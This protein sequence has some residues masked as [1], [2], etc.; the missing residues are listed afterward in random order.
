MD[1]ACKNLVRAS[2]AVAA[3][4]GIS[5]LAASAAAGGGSDAAKPPVPLPPTA[6][7]IEYDSAGGKL[8]F[9]STAS[10]KELAVFYRAA[11]GAEGWVNHPTPINKDTIA[12][13]EFVRGKSG[14]DLTF[15]RIGDHT[16]VS[17]HGDALRDGATEAAA[18]GAPDTDLTAEDK[19]GLPVP[20]PHTLAGSERTPFRTSVNAETPAD[21]AAVVAFYRSEL[22]KRGWAEQV[23][24][25]SVRDDRAELIFDS[26]TGPATLMLTRDGANTTA[27]LTVRDKAAAMKSTLWPKPGQVKVAFGNMTDKAVE[28]SVAGKR[29]KIAAG[30]GRGAPN[31]PTL[32]LAP[33]KYDLA[34]K[35]G[36]HEAIEAGPE[37]IWMAMVGPGGLLAVQAY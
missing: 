2:Y 23:D 17:G 29:V 19:D 6:Q 15:I 8:D 36:E 14:L 31:G 10:V 9:R 34:L 7:D 3:A 18:A 12:V 22:G 28:V 24:K 11:M 26:P 30:A 16:E 33:G 13:L 25:T 4:L 21:I 5:I 35:S 32:D 20:A 1:E 27:Q 37:E